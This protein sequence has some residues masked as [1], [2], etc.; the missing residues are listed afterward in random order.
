MLWCTLIWSP[1]LVA[2]RRNGHRRGY[3]VCRHF[4]FCSA[5]DL[6]LRLVKRLCFG[7]VARCSYSLYMYSL[8][9]LTPAFLVFLLC[10]TKNKTI[11]LL[12]RS[13]EENAHQ[14]CKTMKTANV[15]R[16]HKTVWKVLETRLISMLDAGNCGTRL[17]LYICIPIIICGHKIETETFF[18]RR[19]WFLFFFSVGN[20]DQT[21]HPVSQQK[22]EKRQ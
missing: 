5:I 3:N 20:V 10:S 14:W 9:S 1:H 15:R 7:A 13:K 2:L 4:L 17:L 18:R 16:S 22:R 11:S 6:S 8:L 21:L 19:L 12:L